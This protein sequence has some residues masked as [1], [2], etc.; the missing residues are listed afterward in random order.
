MHPIRILSR[1]SL[2]RVVTFVFGA[3]FVS[4]CFAI[5]GYVVANNFKTALQYSYMRALDDLGYY[6]QSINTELTKGIYAGTKAQFLATVNKLSTDAAQAKSNLAILPQAGVDLTNTYKFLSQVGEYSLSLNKKLTTGGSITD[7]E[8]ENMRKL[9]EYS[10]TM[11]DEIEVMRSI[12]MDEEF[13]KGQVKQ[14]MEKENMGNEEGQSQEQAVNASPEGGDEDPS[15]EKSMGDGYGDLEAGF[16]GYPSL[17]YDGPFSD[18]LLNQ[19]PKFTE[20]LS[21]VDEAYAAAVASKVSG[22][23]ASELGTPGMENS[24][25]PSYCFFAG[26]ISVAVTKAGGI[27]V[28]M[29]NNRA[30]GGA[31]IDADRAVD[32]AAKFLEGLG[33]KDLK[34]TYYMVSDNVCTINFASSIGSTVVYPDLI[35]VLV[36]LD[37]GSICGYDARGY[38]MNHKAR[39]LPADII[40]KTEGLKSVSPKLSVESV[41]TAI[42]PT[43][44]GKEVFC[45]EY[46]CRGQE[47]E[48]ILAYIDAQTGEAV[49]LLILLESENGSLT[50]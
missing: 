15:S 40:S 43:D 14:I 7:E 8:W 9:S 19:T 42:I 17:I 21:D 36:A 10:T 13:L 50:I 41:E 48:R 18:H 47:D 34:T 27:P 12:I 49:K 45:Y 28:Y 2:I 20:G 4:V 44:S 22:L 30:I 26:E 46:K 29:T 24:T 6:T 23:P 5:S 25:M 11:S 32:N 33:F 1:R 16:S 3:L 38:I 31:N 35:K 37:N 39:T